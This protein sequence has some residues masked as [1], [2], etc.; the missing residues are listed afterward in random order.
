MSDYMALP[1]VIGQTVTP[2]VLLLLDNSDSM[3]DLAC[4]SAGCGKRADGITEVRSLY[5]KKAA[6]S[7]FPDSLTCYV[8]DFVNR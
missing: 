3:Q 5:Q 2:N 6:Y 1:P 7:G 8:Y 4:W